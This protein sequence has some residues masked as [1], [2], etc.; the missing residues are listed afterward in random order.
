MEIEVSSEKPVPSFPVPDF[1]RPTVI[2]GAEHS[3][4]LTKAQMGDEFYSGQHPMCRVAS[5]LFFSGGK[6]ED[7]GIRLKGEIDSAKAHAA[8]QGLLG[9]FAPK[10]EIKIGTVGVALAN[11]C[12]PVASSEKAA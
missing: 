7:Y 9:S 8:I 12:V 11:W 5:K 4:Y 10:H 2:F 6:L 1:D 3:A